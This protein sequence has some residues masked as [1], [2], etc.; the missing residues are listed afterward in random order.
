MRSSAGF[1]NIDLLHRSFLLSQTT[2][3]QQ[4]FCGLVDVLRTLTD[5][6]IDVKIELESPEICR[7]LPCKK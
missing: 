1:V 6:F 7:D 2:A 3:S 5:W 4:V